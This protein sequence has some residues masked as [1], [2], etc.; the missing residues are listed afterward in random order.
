MFLGIFE[1][2]QMFL[3]L[4]SHGWSSA[5][6]ASRSSSIST[7]GID[8]RKVASPWCVFWSVVLTLVATFSVTSF[9]SFG[10]IG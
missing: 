2:N 5:G 8:Q 7:T 9:F 4:L 1:R 10:G 6:P 3:I